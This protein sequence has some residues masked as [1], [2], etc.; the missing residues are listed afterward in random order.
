MA[1]FAVALG[2]HKLDCH[3][4]CEACRVCAILFGGSGWG[5]GGGGGGGGFFWGGG[6]GGGGGQTQSGFVWAVPVRT[7]YS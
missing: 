3:R 6:G 2:A 4:T 5:G 1:L 7:L